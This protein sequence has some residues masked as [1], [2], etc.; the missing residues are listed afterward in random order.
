MLPAFYASRSVIGLLAQPS[1]LVAYQKCMIRW[2][3]CPQSYY[4]SLCALEYPLQSRSPFERGSPKGESALSQPLFS[5]PKT[6]FQR[7]RSTLPGG[8]KHT[9]LNPSTIPV[10]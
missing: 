6:H 1:G 9:F 7:W 4:R 3:L 10:V 8:D 2:T 5:R